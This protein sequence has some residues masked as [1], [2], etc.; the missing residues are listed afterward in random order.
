MGATNNID[1]AAVQAILSGNDL[2]IA[3]DYE[4]AINSV[5][6]AINNGVISEQLINK[7]ALRVIAWKYYKGLL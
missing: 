7:L 6:E 1:N 5:K 2:I 4:Y 3:T